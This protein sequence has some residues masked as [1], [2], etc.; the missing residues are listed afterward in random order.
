MELTYTP[1]EKTIKKTYRHFSISSRSNAEIAERKKADFFYIGRRTSSID[2]LIKSFETGYA[3]ENTDNAKFILNRLA[4]KENTV[5]ELFIV[6][7]STSRKEIAE[8]FSFVSQMADMSEIP[9]IIDASFSNAT[10]IESLRRLEFVDEIIFLNDLNSQKLYA[11]VAFLKKVKKRSSSL[12]NKHQ[13]ET[14]ARG[15]GVTKS[16]AKRVFDIVTSSLILLLASPIMI[17]IALAIKLESKGPVFYISKRAGRGYKVFNFFKFR[18]MY[19]GADLQVKELQHMN[20]Y[21]ADAKSAADP[22]F[23]KINNDPRITK[24]GLFLR[25]TSLDEIP[26]L[27]NVLKGDMSLVGNRPLPLY[28]ASALTTDEWAMRFMAPA[29]I[30]GLWQIKKRG[31]DDMSTEERLN[32]DIDY[33]EKC[34]FMYDLWIMANTPSALI[35]KTNA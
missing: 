8:I 11:K 16:Y 24:V 5:P 2:C 35:Q 22:V 3:A 32:L 21:Q 30:T 18:T 25:K 23:F 20:Q 33:A 15:L 31:Q 28:E 17:L 13:V 19:T 27:V 29:G 6:D 9:F 7:A 26:Q 1:E 4:S 12:N 10:E 14:S 34:N